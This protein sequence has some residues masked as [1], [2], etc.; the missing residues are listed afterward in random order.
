[1]LRVVEAKEGVLRRFAEKIRM[2]MER[3]RERSA[4]PRCP[5]ED[6]EGGLSNDLSCEADEQGKRIDREG[7][8]DTA[9]R[10]Q[11]EAEL[12]DL[13]QLLRTTEARRA[14]VAAQKNM[15]SEHLIAAQ[16]EVNAIIEEAFIAAHILR[17][18]S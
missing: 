1:M 6:V 7:S 3:C 4:G 9:E 5:D 2:E 15:K 18:D 8:P 16:G 17:P 11:L 12:K 13:Q 14:R 10:Q